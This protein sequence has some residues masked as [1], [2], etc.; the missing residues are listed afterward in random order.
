MAHL[1]KFGGGIEGDRMYAH[2][3][4][5]TD[6]EGNYIT[7]SRENGG[8]H[9]DRERT[10]DNYTI[11]EIHSREWVSERLQGV[12]QKPG[13]DKPIETC[14]IIVTL[15]QSEDK[16]PEN[17]RKFFE[18]AYNSLKKQYGK[19]NNIVGAWIHLDEAQPHM[20]FAFLPISERESKQKP[21]Y[22]EKLS[23]RAYWPKKN[24]LQEM[25]RQ[26]QAD[27]DRDM[28]RHIEG[29]YDG[30]TKEQGGNKTI[31]ELKRETAQR[32]KRLDELT[33]KPEELKELEGKHEKPLFGEEYYKLTPHQYK[34][35]R[36]IAQNSIQEKSAA[37]LVKQE[38]T[39]LESENKKLQ[40][41]VNYY[42][43]EADKK[44]EEKMGKKKAD[45]KRWFDAAEREK[46][47]LIDENEELKKENRTLGMATQQEAVMLLNYVRKIGK[48]AEYKKW[49]KAQQATTQRSGIKGR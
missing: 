37:E 34:R 13:Q 19:Y 35:L 25:H 4:R 16:S 32:Q 33:A 44:A 46:L 27:M 31:A 22:K 28:G 1:A 12:Y 47:E 3:S 42:L 8:G 9:I 49:K 7:Y 38:N 23:V 45:L 21:E 2:W 14:D 10:K 17:V 41:W 43:G 20:H 30:R 24:S 6:E 18:S 40:R 26:L 29:L 39:K 11:G 5:A 48:E 36:T 15:P